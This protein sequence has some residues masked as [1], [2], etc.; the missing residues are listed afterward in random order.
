[1]PD[2][3]LEDQILQE[4]ETLKALAQQLKA[5]EQAYQQ[6]VQ[7]LQ[8]KHAEPDSLAITPE[9]FAKY[10]EQLHQQIDKDRMHW[11]ENLE[12]RFQQ[13][14]KGLRIQ[15]DTEGTA[16]ENRRAINQNVI[17]TKQLS[18]S[19]EQFGKEV[20]QIRKKTNQHFRITLIL[21]IITAL[22]SGLNWFF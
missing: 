20:E 15:L 8:Q 10:K 6:A 14:I 7:L 11:V 16:I 5:A 12:Q 4:L 3:Q 13:I 22:L 9:Q 18:Q 1:M 19:I 21:V 2:K 17:E